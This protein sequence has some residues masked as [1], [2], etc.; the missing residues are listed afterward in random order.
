MKNWFELNVIREVRLPDHL[1]PYPLDL[2]YPL[3]KILD[4]QHKIFF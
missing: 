3:E 2:I 4:L 1:S